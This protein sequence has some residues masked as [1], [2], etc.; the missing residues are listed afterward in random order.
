MMVQTFMVFKHKEAR[1][2]QDESMI[3]RSVLKNKIRIHPAG[4]LIVG[5]Y[6]W[7]SVSLFKYSY[8]WK[9]HEKAIN[10]RLPGDI[11][12]SVEIISDDFHA[13]FHKIKNLS[14][15]LDLGNIIHFLIIIG[16]L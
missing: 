7:S 5:L 4:E 8:Y 11:Y 16:I 3:F 10:S 2:V 9:E 15:L 6:L 12:I 13:L 1:T 14:Y